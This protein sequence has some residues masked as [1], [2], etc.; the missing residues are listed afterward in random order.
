MGTTETPIQLHSDPSPRGV[1]WARFV[2]PFLDG[3]E[4]R[5]TQIMV[6]GAKRLEDLVPPSA[7]LRAIDG[8]GFR[9]LLAELPDWTVLAQGV[10]ADDANVFL[11][12]STEEQLAKGVADV[13]SRAPE[14]PS[15]PNRIMLDFWQVG[16]H[17]AFTTSRVIETPDWEGIAHH[18][19]G[20]VR[21][22]IE[23]LLELD[24]QVEDGRIALWHGPPGT[25]KT[26]AI[27]AMARSW[28][29]DRRV[30]VLLDPE[31]IF[32]RSSTLMEVLLDDGH[33]DDKWRVLV[34]EDADELLRHD[35]KDR[36]GQALSR[37]LNL[38]DGIL[39]QGL[40][41][42]VLITTNEPVRQLHPALVRPGRCLS[43]IEFRAFTRR[44]ARDA[45]DT[46]RA[47]TLAELLHGAT[48]AEQPEARVGQYL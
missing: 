42:L 2:A 41:I 20:E 24:P 30:Q 44:E 33:D 43:E 16:S 23:A 38:G 32:S 29:E 6:R 45:L 3:S 12:A 15:E 47:G 40:K 39:G 4:P 7:L 13:R 35:A 18:Y 17:G 11:R 34:V 19:P 27:R 36:V 1:L 25:G 37:L 14:P 9:M 26:T 10:G 46:D 22:G 48:S 21:T 8:E 28:N 5:M 31:I